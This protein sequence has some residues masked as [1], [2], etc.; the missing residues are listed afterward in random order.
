MALNLLPPNGAI[1]FRTARILSSPVVWSEANTFSG[2]V[3]IA[4]AMIGIGITYF[5]PDI[6]KKY[7]TL[8]FFSMLAL[9]LTISFIYVNFL[10]G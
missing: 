2:W 5:K 9:A 10:P 6:A 7:G 1:G 8:L 3:F 4:T